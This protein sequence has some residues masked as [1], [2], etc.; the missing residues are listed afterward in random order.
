MLKTQLCTEINSIDDHNILQ[1]DLDTLSEWS[2]TL[3]IDFIICKSS[4]YK[5]YFSEEFIAPTP[6]H[7]FEPTTYG[8]PN[9]NANQCYNGDILLISKKRNANIVHYI[10]FGNILECVYDHECLGV[11]IS[12]DFCWEKHCNKIAKKAN[13]TLGLLRRTLSPCSKEVKSRDY[14]IIVW[15]K[16]E[17]AA[18]AW[19]SNN[20][21]TAD[22]LEH[23]QRAADRFVHHYRRTTF[24]N[25][26][27]NILR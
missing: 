8:S 21:T 13:K 16:L 6:P 25:N 11:S 20:I 18:E 5:C 15:P 3:L 26:I 4:I 23:I 19:N 1:Q 14:Q 9:Q 2:T 12:H 27:T 7:G 10:I 17:Y 24:V 22:R